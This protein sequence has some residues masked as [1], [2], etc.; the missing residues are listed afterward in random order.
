MATK[1][2]S[3]NEKIRRM[4]V[5]KGMA[6]GD[7]AKRLGVAYQVVFKATSV[8]YAS[9]AWVERLEAAHAAREAAAVIA[10]EA[11]GE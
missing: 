11:A 3:Q 9:K 2:L 5:N 6:R 8:Q 10:V 4:F 1:R 7:I